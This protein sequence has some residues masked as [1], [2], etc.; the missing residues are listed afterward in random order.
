[1][2]IEKKKTEKK[3]QTLNIKRR[4]SNQND[5]YGGISIKDFLKEE[6][7]RRKKDGASNKIDGQAR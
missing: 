2:E 4:W 6:S 1:M 7:R 3:K 5:E